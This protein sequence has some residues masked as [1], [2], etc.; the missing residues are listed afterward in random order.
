[1]VK[2]RSNH[3][4]TCNTR[5]RFNSLMVILSDPEPLEPAADTLVVVDIVKNRRGPK[6]DSEK[7]D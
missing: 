7:V 6:A 1:M 2:A 5:L 3:A 4:T